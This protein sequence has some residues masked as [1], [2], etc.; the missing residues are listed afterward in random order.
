MIDRRDLVAQLC[1]RRDDALMVAGLGSPAWDL[2][3]AGDDTRNFYLWGGMGMAAPT[4]LGLALSQPARKVIAI[5]GD[6]E[7]LMGVGSLATIALQKP[8]NLG[9]LVL[10]NETYG[11]TGGQPSPTGRGVDLAGMAAA[12]GFAKVLRVDTKADVAPAVT[13]LLEEPGPCF[14][15]AKVDAGPRPLRLPPR[16]GALLAQRFRAALK[17]A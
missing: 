11:E 15:L 14:V 17:L 16:D 6:G 3:A 5:T 10:D 1:A 9:I 7:M 13:A 4:A 12:A 2:A 8:T